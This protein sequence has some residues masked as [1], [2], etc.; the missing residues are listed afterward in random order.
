MQTDFYSSLEGKLTLNCAQL[1]PWLRH[2]NNVVYEGRNDAH[3]KK[4]E[5]CR[6]MNICEADL[7]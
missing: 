4:N 1:A 2:T 3:A 5:L 6:D 7:H